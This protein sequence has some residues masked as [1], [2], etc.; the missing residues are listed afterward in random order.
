MEVLYGDLDGWITHLSS[1]DNDH[2]VFLDNKYNL[3]NLV[4]F[5]AKLGKLKKNH[6]DGLSPT[7]LNLPLPPINVE[8]VFS[9]HCFIILFQV[10][11]I[12]FTLKVKQKH[13]HWIWPKHPP[14]IVDLI[15]QNV[16]FIVCFFTY[17]MLLIFYCMNSHM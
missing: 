16:C 1:N 2:S 9:H 13:E 8:Y 17:L 4:G 15:H 10:L 6:F 3:L 14:P 12:I 5:S 11:D 7:H